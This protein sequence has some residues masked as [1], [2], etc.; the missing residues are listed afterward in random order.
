MRGVSEQRELG[1][2]VP[3]ERGVGELHTGDASP[4]GVPA[5]P[6]RFEVGEKAR[7][8]QGPTLIRSWRWFEAEEVGNVLATWSASSAT[9][10]ARRPE[11]GMKRSGSE[12]EHR[13]SSGCN[14]FDRDGRSL[15]DFGRR[16]AL[17]VM[18]AHV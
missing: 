4:A 11:L 15:V 18:L 9:M 5:A 1:G 3:V 12:L 13:G 2:E 17:L 14:G 16:V 7:E 6:A 8:H 10:A